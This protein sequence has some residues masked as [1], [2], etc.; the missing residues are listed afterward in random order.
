[1]FRPVLLVCDDSDRSATVIRALDHNVRD[2]DYLTIAVSDLADGLQILAERRLSLAVIADSTPVSTIEQLHRFT[3]GLAIVAV[4]DDLAAAGRVLQAG[5]HQHIVLDDVGPNS[6]ERAMDRAAAICDVDHHAPDAENVDSLLTLLAHHLREPIRSARLYN[7]R[8]SMAGRQVQWH[9]RIEDVLAHAD[10]LT[11]SLLNYLRLDSHEVGPVRTVDLGSA[12]EELRRHYNSLGATDETLRWA[13][14]GVV[15]C[16]PDSLVEILRAVVDNALIYS[17][18]SQPT[19]DVS[20]ARAKGHVLIRVTDGGPG[21]SSINRERAFRPLERLSDDSP[22]VG[23][24]LARARRLAGLADGEL[25]IQSGTSGGT[26]VV[27]R[28]QAA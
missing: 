16:Q 24:G 15:R 2:G 11:T 3:P 20:S 10:H 25:F 26:T 8:A 9:G 18:S 5:A 27:L 17:G 7:D 4:V 19:V 28:L 12:E 23:M 22:G 13:L 14:E 21:I 1:M 6:I